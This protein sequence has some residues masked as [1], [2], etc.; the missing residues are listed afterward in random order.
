M[1]YLHDRYGV[2]YTDLIGYICDRRMPPGVG[3]ILREELAEFDSQLDRILE[4]QGRGREMPEY[5]GIYWDEE[6][7][8]VLRISE[9][10][11]EFYDEMLVLV[12]E[13][14]RGK[15]ISWDDDELTEVAQYQRLRMPSHHP[16]AIKEWRFNSNLPE[17]FETCFRS[18]AK[19]LM[20][21]PQMM[22]LHPKDY[23]GNKPRY[24]RETILRGRKSGAM[25]LDATWRD[26]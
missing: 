21:K 7:A 2:R 3:N 22:A 10:L 25:L 11:D 23:Q 14:L 13:F 20:A 17:Y 26:D 8:S 15:G 19:P 16:R 1:Y 5:G 18:D 4:G 9:K 6:E 24:A 12:C